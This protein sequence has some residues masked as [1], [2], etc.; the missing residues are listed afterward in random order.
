MILF[1]SLFLIALS[2][3]DDLIAVMYLLQMLKKGELPWLNAMVKNSI[4]VSFKK[5]RMAKEM[6]GAAIII[7]NKQGF[8]KRLLAH[9][10]LLRREDTPDY[11]Y[12]ILEMKRHLSKHGEKLDW[13]MDWTNYSTTWLSSKDFFRKAFDCFTR[14]LSDDDYL[15]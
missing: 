10:L 1:D 9:V 15:V 6:Y 2:P 5:I 14:D 7:Q 11:D 12:Y 8:F 4:S 3:R 13:V